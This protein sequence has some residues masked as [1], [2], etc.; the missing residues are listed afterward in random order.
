MLERVLRVNPAHHDALFR[1]AE[2]YEKLE[3][4]PDAIRIYREI[5]QR[6]RLQDAEANAHVRLSDIYYRLGQSEQAEEELSWVVENRPTLLAAR[7]D[8]GMIR[9]YKGDYDSAIE[10]LSSWVTKHPERV[11]DAY[12]LARAHHKRS[13]SARI[14][15]NEARAIEDA[16]EAAYWYGSILDSVPDHT[17]ALAEL[18]AVLPP[19]RLGEAIDR[20]DAGI[21]FV[22][23]AVTGEEE[24][25]TK[26]LLRLG[27]LSS[28]KAKALE[29]SDL[30][31]M[32]ELA[33]AARR[34]SME[35]YRQALEKDPSNA[36]ALEALAAGY[37][38]AGDWENAKSY[39]QRLSELDP[40]D[41][42]L[43]YRLGFSELQLREYESATKH[44]RDGLEHAESDAIRAILYYYLGI[45]EFFLKDYAAAE[46][47]LRE[48][49]A[50]AEES[51]DFVMQLSMVLL[52]Q[53]K[54]A[55]AESLL[56][57][58]LE[59]RP[60]DPDLSSR[61]ALVYGDQ[62]KFAEAIELLEKAV[63]KHP[64]DLDLQVRL[65]AFC[66]DQGETERAE[67][68]LE[69]AIGKNPKDENLYLQL[70][71]LYEKKKAIDRVEEVI[72]RLLQIHENSSAAFNFLGYTY[73]DHNIKLDEAH[74]LIT[75]ALAIEPD[76]GMYVDSLGWVYYRQ[77]KYR[78][79]VV[80]LRR[81]VELLGE[82]P[83]ILE[84]L[85]DALH[86]VGETDE[87]LTYWRKAFD[88]NPDNEELKEKID[89]AKQARQ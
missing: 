16:S 6:F 80:E 84:H 81:A 30:E 75:K 41:P 2:L 8:L 1:L 46:E 34:Q 24:L 38:E 27:L 85:G 82:D 48:G 5:L 25:S 60:E 19:E 55:E 15:G 29:E 86:A 56:R 51:T 20:Y 31:G 3:R 69:A 79:A 77:G 72:H 36:V 28:A 88:T 45:G 47:G 42:I 7:R 50:L 74:Q 11:G 37:Q 40:E 49:M 9:Y 59:E 70:A 12:H 64:D 21:A 33:D 32:A 43:L 66:G 57:G 68:I 67:S 23:K 53:E 87:A 83:V 52:R 18:A 65:A 44:F 61:L 62:K 71:F 26:Q 17:G 54:F 39:Y 10:L 22:T 63:E 73:A 58:A 76:N 89:G 78:E 35:R 13:E 14:K 4:W